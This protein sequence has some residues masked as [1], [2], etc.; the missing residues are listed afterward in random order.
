M[1]EIKNVT[2]RYGKIAALSDFNLSVKSGSI[3]GLVGINGA[4]KSTLLRLLAGVFRAEEGEIFVD[5]EPIFEN[6][7][8]K[9]EIFFLPDEPFYLPGMNGERMADLYKAF[10]NFDQTVF[11]TC[12]AAY[13][14]S[15]KAPLRT[16]SKG[17]KRQ[18]F[19]SLAFAAQPKYLLLDEVFDGLD[20]AARLVFKR[21][22][23]DLLAKNGG[24]AVISSHS[25]RELED[26]CDSYGVIDGKKIMSS[27]VLADLLEDMYKFQ[28][29]FN[30]PVL[31]E[32]LGFEC[33]SF[34]SSGRIIKIV[35]RGKREEYLAKI[36]K[37]KP[38]IVDEVPVDFEEFFI[39]EMQ[40]RY[41]AI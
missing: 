14:L 41:G 24:T 25:L 13:G 3:F 15:L 12:I 16:F 9:K 8:K 28:I 29:A 19:V 39:S 1:I 4:G 23:V 22:L 6:E 32:D 35:V 2:K 21:G 33:V 38:L 34:E 40:G 37:L 26:I 7:K 36:D 11:N 10:Y 5:G 31:K 17:M 18:L 27:G 30:K 20:P